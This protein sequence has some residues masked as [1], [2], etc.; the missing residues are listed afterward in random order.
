MEE[1][2]ELLYRSFDE[3]LSFEEQLILEQALR[4]DPELRKEKQELEALRTGLQ[5]LDLSFEPGFVDR[6]MSKTQETAESKT[7]EIQT[8]FYRAFKRV[9]LFGAA[10][11]IALL[12]SVYFTDGS[13]DLDAMFGLSE[14]DVYEAELS[15]FDHQEIN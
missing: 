12:F 8:T 10:A 14:F 1:L 7:V 4:D 13:L 2:K 11:I 6:V 5:E 9:A 15:Y 3:H